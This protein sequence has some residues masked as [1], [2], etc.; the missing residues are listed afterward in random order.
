LLVRLELSKIFT[1]L[2]LCPKA[3]EQPLCL[4]REAVMGLFCDHG[5][6]DQPLETSLSEAPD[7]ILV[8]DTIL[9]NCEGYAY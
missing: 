4:N 2:T 5:L 6:M 8:H 3:S 7:A 1:T 9:L